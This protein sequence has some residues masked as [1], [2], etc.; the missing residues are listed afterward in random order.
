VALRR[1][2]Y[3]YRIS[4][5]EYVSLNTSDKTSL[6]LASFL[7]PVIQHYT[8][9]S[10]NC[11][12]V[13]KLLKN[14]IIFSN[15]KATFIAS[16]LSESL[17]IL[18]ILDQYF[19]DNKSLTS[20]PYSCLVQHFKDGFIGN[21]APIGIWLRTCSAHWPTKVMFSHLLKS[22]SLLDGDLDGEPL[23][24]F[25]IEDAIIQALLSSPIIGVIGLHPLLNGNQIMTLLK[26]PSGRLIGEYLNALVIYQIKN[27]M[28]KP[29]TKE[30]AI[31]YIT[32]HSLR[33]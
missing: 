20:K 9:L 30:D 24:L 8:H 19:P 18:Q 33:E 14:S 22:P 32:S 26:L 1:A 6:L 5:L 17:Q 11:N 2:Y 13:I 23:Q 4:C 3:A 7:S 29:M 10:T 15:Y 16:F 25:V 28:N 21:P 31:H 27:I 12:N